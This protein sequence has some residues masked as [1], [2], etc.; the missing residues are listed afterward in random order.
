[1][2]R[3]LSRSD[4]LLFWLS[5]C[6]LPGTQTRVDQTPRLEA[7]VH[8]LSPGTFATA[9][10]TGTHGASWVSAGAYRSRGMACSADAAGGTP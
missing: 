5:P 10:R 3:E 4:E 9:A 8:P 7:G 1:V 2:P 6:C